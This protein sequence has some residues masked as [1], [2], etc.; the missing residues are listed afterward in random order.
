MDISTFVQIGKENLLALNQTRITNSRLE[1]KTDFATV[2]IFVTLA[3]IILGVLL[4][5]S[6]KLKKSFKN[7]PT[8][9][10]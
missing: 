5:T 7:S 1:F 4:L 8:N 10:C 3:I 6:L 2:L 9:I